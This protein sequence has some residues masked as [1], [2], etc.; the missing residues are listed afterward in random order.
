MSSDLDIWDAAAD[1]W[2]SKVTKPGSLRSV[3]LK[4]GVDELV[5]N[6]AGKKILDAGC[7]DGVFTNYLHEQKADIVG[8]DGSAKMIEWA[9]QKYPHLRFDVVD[10]LKPLPFADQS[11]D[12]ILSNMVMM[13]LA[14]VDVFFKHAYRVLKN[15]GTLV[16]SVLHPCFNFPTM[17]LYK[18]WWAKL[19]FKK[20]SGLSHDYFKENVSRRYEKNLSQVLTHYHRTLEDYS[21]KLDQHGFAINRLLEPHHLTNDFIASNPK[22]EYTTRLPRFLFFKCTKI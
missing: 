11:F 17:R 4:Y 20:P 9:K 12:L 22:M 7:G 18:S 15:N 5:K 10:M 16:F 13:H 2:S 19:L 21:K 3:H 6:A 8:I 14:D 1:S